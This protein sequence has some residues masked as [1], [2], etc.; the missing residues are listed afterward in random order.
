MIYK[1]IKYDC[2]R[3]I[4]NSILIIILGILSVVILGSGHDT[5]TKVIFLIIF[6][7]WLGFIS[8]DVILSYMRFKSYEEKKRN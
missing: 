8:R 2:F 7:W 5:K 1:F 6:G 3:V 4:S